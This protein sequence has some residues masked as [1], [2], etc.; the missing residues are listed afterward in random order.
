MCAT[1]AEEAYVCG[2][3]CQ[4]REPVS[5][6]N[7]VVRHGLARNA[8]YATPAPRWRLEPASQATPMLIP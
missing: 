7:A 1:T 4:L 3:S 2:I 5:L 6:L 8:D